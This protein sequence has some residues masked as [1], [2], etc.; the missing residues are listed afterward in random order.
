LAVHSI[1]DWIPMACRALVYD[2][3]DWLTQRLDFALFA[4]EHSTP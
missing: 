2:L 1:L 4:L 3:C